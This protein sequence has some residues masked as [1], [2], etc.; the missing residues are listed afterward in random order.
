MVFPQCI[1]FF[2]VVIVSFFLHFY[3]DTI[4][5]LANCLYVQILVERLLKGSTQQIS[6]L[7]C[8]MDDVKHYNPI[9][10]LKKGFFII[11]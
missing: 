9:H 3:S 11:Q 2:T 8:Y 5:N 4:I 10:S 7:K 6:V 1:F